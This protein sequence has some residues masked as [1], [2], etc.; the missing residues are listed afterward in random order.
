M[1]FLALIL[2]VTTLISGCSKDDPAAPETPRTAGDFPYGPAWL[3]DRLPANTLAYVRVPTIFNLVSA[4]KNNDLGDML[5][6][7][8]HAEII[9]ELLAGLDKNVVQKPGLD[10]AP[11]AWILKHQRSPLEIGVGPVIGSQM[12]TPVMTLTVA[13]D[14]DSASAM[15]SALEKLLDEMESGI[16]VAEFDDNGVAALSGLPMP[17]QLTFDVESKRLFLLAGPG[18]TTE[19]MLSTASALETTNASSPIQDLENKIDSSGHGLF[20]WISARQS[21]KMAQ[22]F[23]PPEVAQTLNEMS[24]GEAEAVAMGYGVSNGK[25]RLTMLADVPSTGTGGRGLVPIADHNLDLE[26]TAAPLSIFVMNLP[27]VDELMALVNET[28]MRE[29][30]EKDGSSFEG[31]LAKLNDLVGTDLMALYGA[32]DHTFAYVSD[33]VGGYAGIRVTDAEL[34]TNAIGAIAEKHGSPL[35]AREIAGRTYY[36]WRIPSALDIV[37]EEDRE[38]FGIEE[39]SDSLGAFFDIY[40]RFGTHLFFTFDDDQFLMAAAPQTLMDR[41][42]RGTPLTLTEW[43]AETQQHD[44]SNAAFG[45]SASAEGIPRFAHQTYISSLTA[46]ADLAETPIDYFSLPTADDLDLGERGTLGFSLITDERLMGMEFVFEHSP[47][48]MLAGGNGVTTIAVVGILAAIAVPAYQ[49]YT[50]RAQVS[51]GLTLSADTR[52]DIESFFEA[53]ERFPDALESEDYYRTGIGTYADTIAVEP[54]SGTVFVYFDGP[55][56]GGQLAGSR[57]FLYPYGD[58]EDG[59]IE[60]YCEAEFDAKYLPSFCQ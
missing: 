58:D 22:L 60:W 36:H 9:T 13:T 33:P 51:E 26:V 54:D 23:I 27:S 38:A 39:D 16:A 52:S 21:M 11:I 14:F 44:L 42:R 1:R 24:L 20:M 6:S 10:F 57:L 53:N 5:G 49:D 15:A 47:G 45:F 8:A 41:F 4:P 3:A 29:A 19:R 12:Q 34:I 46:M 43:L 18:A 28:P 7:E 55:K 56:A 30:F 35:T 2:I 40:A 50:L 25:A 32:F 59:S 37:P 17:A 31:A 48:D